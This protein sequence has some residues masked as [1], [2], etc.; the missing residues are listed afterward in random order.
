MQCDL[1]RLSDLCQGKHLRVLH[2]ANA[3]PKAEQLKAKS[4]LVRTSMEFLYLDR[5]S[6]HSHVQCSSLIQLTNWACIRS[7]GDLAL[8]TIH[9]EVQTQKGSAISFKI[10]S[11]TN[12]KKTSQIVAA[13]TILG[14]SR[15]LLPHCQFEEKVQAPGGPPT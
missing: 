10:S 1:K 13:F 11:P 8:C 7:L 5:P 15:P 3:R 2:D 6:T 9:Q 14:S 12:P 4:C